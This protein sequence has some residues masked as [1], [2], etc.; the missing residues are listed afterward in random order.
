MV[1]LIFQSVSSEEDTEKINDLLKNPR[2]AKA[3]D[4]SPWWLED[5]EKKKGTDLCASV[6]EIDYYG[7]NNLYFDEYSNKFVTL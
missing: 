6:K 2:K 5:D 7:S 1:L 4:Q 3:K